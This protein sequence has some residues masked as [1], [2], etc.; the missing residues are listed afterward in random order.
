MKL[1]EFKQNKLQR[2]IKTI[3]RVFSAFNIEMTHI[4]TIE[5]L[6]ATYIRCRLK[7]IKDGKLAKG[8]ERDLSF[9]L[10]LEEVKIEIPIEGG[11]LINISI[12]NEDKEYISWDNAGTHK[13]Y[14][15]PLGDL[16]IPIGKD[17]L[18]NDLIINLYE[19]KNLLICGCSGSGKSTLLH[20]II[21]T[22]FLR[23]SPYRIKFLMIDTKQVEFS[24]Y[25]SIP[26]LLIPVIN[27]PNDIISTLKWVLEQMSS[28]SYTAFQEEKLENI[29]TSLRAVIR[30]LI[31]ILIDD[32]SDIEPQYL[33]EIENLI[34]KIVKRDF[35]FGIHLIV[36]T[37]YINTKLKNN[38][39]TEIIPAHI[40]LKITLP[41]TS[42]AMLGNID[43]SNL[44]YRGDIIFRPDIM[45]S[46]IRGQV[47][48]ISE[49][50][51]K[52][53]IVNTYNTYSEDTNNEINDF[54]QTIYES[55]GSGF[56]TRVE[57]TDELYEK[58]KKIVIESGKASTS[59]IQRKL[60]I[61]YSRSA[62]LIGLLERNGIVGPESGSKPREVYG[63]KS[64]E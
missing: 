55:Y 21:N 56:G 50:E 27:K 29:D 40:A 5:G 39:I 12:P 51:I 16:L 9:V 7:N 58:A 53:N 11:T 45:R 61:G 25:S 52:K 32:L 59:Y 34:T 3:L 36:S 17:E 1:S 24:L 63:D 8:L 47:A 41:Q 26:N 4:D 10:A 37:S 60:N 23:N 38:L 33:E 35:I 15:D 20:T 48:Y 62:K 43:A 2:R 44:K 46:Q 64:K 14:K 19:L 31:V 28:R 13:I 57:E 54:E 49:E 22:L 18:G 30:P 6:N 42:K